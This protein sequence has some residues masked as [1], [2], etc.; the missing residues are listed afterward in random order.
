MSGVRAK[1]DTMLYIKEYTDNN[2]PIYSTKSNWIICYLIKTILP[3]SLDIKI[4]KDQSQK[5]EKNINLDGYISD[6]DDS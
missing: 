3:V 1:I 5:K 6:G 4:E 2:D